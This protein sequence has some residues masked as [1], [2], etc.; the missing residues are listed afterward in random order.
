MNRSLLVCAALAAG[1][2]V[3]ACGG[4]DDPGL[5]TGWDASRDVKLPDTGRD[6]GP[7]DKGPGEDGVKVDVAA[8]A[9]AGTDVLDGCPGFYLCPCDRN[10]QCYSGYC[11]ESRE[12]WLCSRTCQTDEGCPTGWKCSQVAGTGGADSSYVCIDPYARL[13]QPCK[14]TGDCRPTVGAGNKVHACMPFGEPGSFCGI[15]C[16]QDFECPEGFSCQDTSDERDALRQCMPDAGVCECTPKFRAQGNK[17]ECYFENQ[18]G[19]CTGERSC[20]TD[21]SARVP[22]AEMC[23]LIDDNCDGKTDEDLDGLHCDITNE[24]GTCPGET[25]CQNGRERCIGLAP[26]AESCNGND[27]NCDGVVDEDGAQGCIVYFRDEDGDGTGV[28][29]DSKCL[30]GPTSIYRALKGGDCDDKDPAVFPGAVEICNGKD[31][32]CNGLIDEEGAQG[33]RIYFRDEDKDGFGVSDDFLCLCIATV[34]YTAMS[35]GDCDDSERLVNPSAFE[36]CSGVDDNCDGRTDSEGAQG[37]VPH[38]RDG[39]DDGYGVTGDLKCLCAAEGVYRA[40]MAGDCKDDNPQV[41]P[42]T[43]ELCNG[44]DDNCNGQTDEENAAGCTVFYKDNDGDSYGVTSDTKCLCN[45]A[46]KYTAN[47]GGDCND[48]DNS[49]NPGALETCNGKD[50][51]CNG[52]T[53][54]EGAHGCQNRWIDWDRDGYGLT[55]TTPK[56]LCM[57]QFING[58]PYF[59]TQI[60]DCNDVDKTVYPGAPERCDN[61]DN[62]CDGVIDEEGSQGCVLYYRD[63]DGDGYGAPDGGRCLC[64][65]EGDYKVTN[66]S[67]CC[68]T[69]NRA[70]PGQTQFY[71]TRNNCTSWDYNCNNSADRE[72]ANLGSCTAWSV[73]GGCDPIVG[74]DAGSVPSCGSSASFMK[75]CSKSGLSCDEDRESRVQRCN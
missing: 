37:C 45:A 42:G 18:H 6:Q 3:V 67:D 10:D 13:C 49:V 34:P 60:G 75:G 55:G 16:V 19:L 64:K 29:D 24:F 15:E 25:A 40:T 28:S 72:F 4:P 31:N 63:I 74:W 17:T 61:Q 33:C 2:V 52:Q 47:R 11:I 27:D 56:C 59:G 68:D 73:F 71:T 54:P 39:D 9:D 43:Q 23:N 57:S 38:Y 50:D 58:V 14:E 8:D 46:E 35:G 69:D 66:G 26:R 32:N 12:Q 53:D 36:R 30:C 5:D 41:S 65:P 22:A 1:L 44:Q 20:D 51:N 7:A 48:A 62:N 21:C 70:K